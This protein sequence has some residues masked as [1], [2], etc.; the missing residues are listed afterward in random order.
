MALEQSQIHFAKP[1][2]YPHY[3]RMETNDGLEK[4][5][6]PSCNQLATESHRD[7]ACVRTF[8]GSSLHFSSGRAVE[9]PAPSVQRTNPV[10]SIM[11][12]DGAQLPYRDWGPA[13]PIVFRHG[14]PLSSGGCRSDM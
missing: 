13:Q 9:I 5:Y 3:R 7:C 8:A 10:I 1:S 4:L 12:K 6:Q 14:W 11:T 2:R